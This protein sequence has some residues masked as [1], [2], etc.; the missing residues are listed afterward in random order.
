MQTLSFSTRASTCCPMKS[1]VEDANATSV[2]LRD[3]E[4]LARMVMD[5]T[6]GA[7]S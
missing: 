6:E 4:K 1:A 2:W 3:R 7:D 5:T